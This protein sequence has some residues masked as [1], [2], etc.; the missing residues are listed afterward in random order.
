MDGCC[1]WKAIN[2]ELQ[3]SICGR[4][5]GRGSSAKSEYRRN[6][7]REEFGLI[8]LRPQLRV[9]DPSSTFP[10][11]VLPDAAARS[12]PSPRMTPRSR[13]T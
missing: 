4:A 2:C 7:E 9:T 3:A 5:F 1:G 8:L 13:F 11:S 12:S 6:L 10:G